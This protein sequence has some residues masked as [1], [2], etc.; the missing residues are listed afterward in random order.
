MLNL[1]LEMYETTEFQFKNSL[2]VEQSVTL[3]TSY[4][5]NLSYNEEHTKCIA[6]FNIQVGEEPLETSHLL[7][8]LNSII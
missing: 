4:E 7:S 6:L 2:A 8:S 3:K 5:L 1:N